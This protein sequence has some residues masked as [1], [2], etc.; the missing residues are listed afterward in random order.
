MIKLPPVR[1]LSRVVGLVVLAG[2]FLLVGSLIFATHFVTGTIN[3][4]VSNITARS[5]LSPFLVRGSVI[6][7]TIPFFWA[8]AK[9][10][11]NVLGLL[12]LGWAPLSL[13]RNVYGLIIIGYISCFFLSMYWASREAYAYKYCGETPEGIFV[14]DG[15]G[16]DPVYGVQLAPCSIDQIKVLRHGEGDLR[17]PTEVKVDDAEHF[18]WYDAMTGKA[19]VWYALLPNGD[20]RFFDRPGSDPNTG[21]QLRPVTPDVVQHMRSEEEDSRQQKQRN[22]D[23]KAEA[24]KRR[25]A[26][27]SDRQAAENRAA[28]LAALVAEGSAQFQSANYKDARTTCERALA[29]EP[30][31]APCGTIHQRS[32]VKLAQDFVREG[33][34]QFQQG[35]F[36]EAIWSAESAIALDPTNMNAIKLKKLATLTKPHSLN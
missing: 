23:L 16:K 30:T 27:A 8:V 31:N 15:P 5:G 2:L 29:I 7:L 19:R 36:D 6:I 20:Y 28:D 33:Q 9:F 21:Q 17:R 12:G 26:A 1:G 11:R 32:G 35:E 24:A 34:Q 22:A 18:E 13:Y 4:V 25:L 14:S 3:Y 10:T